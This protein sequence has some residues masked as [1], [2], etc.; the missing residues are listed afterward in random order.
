MPLLALHGDSRLRHG[1]ALLKPRAAGGAVILVN[2]HGEIISPRSGCAPSLG[3]LSRFGG[4]RFLRFLDRG[5]WRRFPRRRCG[6]TALRDRVPRPHSL[7]ER[8]LWRH[9]LGP[10]VEDCLR[11]RVRW[12]NPALPAVAGDTHPAHE[13][14]KKRE[15]KKW[16]IKDK[17][18]DGNPAVT[19]PRP[20]PSAGTPAP[21][22]SIPPH[23][24]SRR[25]GPHRGSRGTR[26]LRPA[27]ALPGSSPAT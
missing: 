24:R 11:Y 17:S 23:I 18:V 8:L 5:R 19:P 27:R 14:A 6:A 25:N 22:R 16:T 26:C 13:L 20:P 12:L 3:L 7:V 15:H 21:R 10:R 2:G 4:R 9:D 1:T